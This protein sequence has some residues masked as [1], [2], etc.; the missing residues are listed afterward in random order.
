[1]KASF[2]RNVVN[3]KELL[4]NTAR[5]SGIIAECSVIQT[6][7]LEEEQYVDF[8]NAFQE[9]CGFLSP[10]FNEAVIS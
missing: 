4:E 6:I 7:V 10:F 9:T 2:F 8:C 5:Y 1:M 3:Y